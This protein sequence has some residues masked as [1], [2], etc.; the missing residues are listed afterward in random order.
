MRFI[1]N[2]FFLFSI[3]SIVLLWSNICQ[4]EAQVSTETLSATV[5]ADSKS[6]CQNGTQPIITF[7]GAGGSAPYTFSYTINGIEQTAV[8]SASEST[9]TINVSTTEAGSFTYTLTKVTDKNNNSQDISSQ[10]VNIIIN[11]LPSISGVTHICELEQTTTLQSA[12]L[13]AASLAWQSSDPSIATINDT[14]QATSKAVGSTNITYTDVNGCAATVKLAVNLNP[15]VDFTFQD[16]QCAGAAIPFDSQVSDSGTKTYTYTYK[17]DFGDGQTS[18]EKKP[19][20]FFNATGTNTQSFDI[21]LSVKNDTTGCSVTTS[22]KTLTLTQ[23]PDA[24]LISSAPSETSNGLTVFRICASSPSTFSFTNSSSTKSSN[25][26]SY[27]IDWGDNSPQFTATTWNSTTHTYAVG[28]WTLQYSIKGKHGCDITK[29]YNV[30]VG[31]NPSVGLVNPGNTSICQTEKI[32]FPINNTENNPLGTVYQFDFGDGTDTTFVHP[33]PASISHAYTHTSCGNTTPDG[34]LNSFYIRI[35][36]SNPCG[37]TRNSTAI[38]VS[39]PPV[40][41]IALL[42]P[43]GCV[44]RSFPAYS[45]TNATEVTGSSCNTQPKLVWKISSSN[46]TLINSS[47]GS[48]NGSDDVNQWTPG[49]QVIYPKFTTKGKY[50]ISLRTGNRCNTSTKDTVI[51]IEPLLAKP[52]FN[53]DKTNDCM[54]LTVNAT[55]TTDINNTCSTPKY[56]WEVKSYVPGYG[57]FYPQYSCSDP[58]AENPTFNFTTPG[59]YQSFPHNHYCLW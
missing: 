29:I 54:P 31:S 53:L 17:W 44:N 4:S 34:A 48:D 55:N 45:L 38:Q 39:T 6:V 18:T 12:S 51:C 30:F 49:S 26:D 32:S 47:L 8:S 41:R 25:N 36:A 5:T 16:N 1:S 20:H 3:L 52:T 7:T 15:H 43:T 13:P 22:K 57:G 2:R 46:Y 10:T 23:S 35:I 24:A 11:A 27:T 58:Y 50:T 33:A 37:D 42:Y 19:S 21:Q 9:V 56:F 14:G 28:L 40:A 59:T